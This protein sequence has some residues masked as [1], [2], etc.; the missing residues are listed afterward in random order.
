M[1]TLHPARDP[2]S[3]YR[4][5]EDSLDVSP[6]TTCGVTGLGWSCKSL[7]LYD[8]GAISMPPISRVATYYY[9]C[10]RDS[11][12]SDNSTWAESYPG[13]SSPLTIS[14]IQEAYAKLFSAVWAVMFGWQGCMPWV[15]CLWTTFQNM[16]QPVNSRLATDLHCISSLRLLPFSKKIIPIWQDIMLGVRETEVPQMLVHLSAQTPANHA[17]IIRVDCPATRQQ[18]ASLGS[19]IQR[20]CQAMFSPAADAGGDLTLRSRLK[21]GY[22]PLPGNIT[23]VNT[24]CFCLY[25]LLKNGASGAVQARDCRNWESSTAAGF[26]PLQVL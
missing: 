11:R 16:L 21:R 22:R 26:W 19:V 2:V 4:A 6:G 17:R 9:L 7:T 1:V 8:G 13:V 10:Q 25:R 18:W 24:L 5:D 12:H 15:G 14:F 3:L 20:E 23:L